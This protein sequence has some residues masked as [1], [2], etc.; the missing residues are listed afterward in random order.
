MRTNVRRTNVRRT[1]C[2]VVLLFSM[3]NLFGLGCSPGRPKPERGSMPPQEL[4]DELRFRRLGRHLIVE[5]MDCEFSD[6]DLDYKI[7]LWYA[8]YKSGAE[9]LTVETHHFTPQGDSPA[10]WTGFALLAESHVSVHT[11]PEHRYVAVDIFTCGESMDMRKTL[12]FL[13]GVFKPGRLHYVGVD[14]GYDD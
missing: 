12:A 14:R 6:M 9:V 7:L 2:L 8:A 1:I 3:V 11:W 5:F 13:I 10:G 4:N